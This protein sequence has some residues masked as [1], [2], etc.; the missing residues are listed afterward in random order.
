[1]RV[2]VYLKNPEL[3]CR[4]LLECGCSNAFR[5]RWYDT[6]TTLLFR[7]ALMLGGAA[8]PAAPTLNHDDFVHEKDVLAAATAA[9]DAAL[10]AKGGSQA[11]RFDLH[12]SD[13][14][15]VH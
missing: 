13:G 10:A 6:D 12:A 4:L 2:R 15:Y 7:R 5:P 9:N 1:V 14:V 8:D 3:I 11:G